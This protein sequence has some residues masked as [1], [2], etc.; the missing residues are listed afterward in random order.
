MFEYMYIKLQ[1]GMIKTA[2]KTSINILTLYFGLNIIVRVA[3]EKGLKYYSVQ[4]LRASA[5]KQ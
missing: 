3:Y 4:R 1:Q 5:L 2:I